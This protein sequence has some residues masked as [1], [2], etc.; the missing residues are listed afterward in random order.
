M[1]DADPLQDIR[2]T[3]KI[4]AVVLRGKLLSRASLDAL[5]AEAE[6]LGAGN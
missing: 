4:D 5:L 2:N 3:T 1:L 6:Q